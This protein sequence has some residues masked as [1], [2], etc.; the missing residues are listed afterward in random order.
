MRALTAS[1]LL[2][3]F[4]V[5]CPGPEE[6]PDAGSTDAGRVDAGAAD[7]GVA[8]AGSQ[9]D[10]GSDAG[11]PDAGAADAGARLEVTGLSVGI[12]TDRRQVVLAWTGNAARVRVLRTLNAAASGPFDAAAQVVFDGAASGASERVDALLP[13]VAGAPRRYT[14]SAFGCD[15]AN[16]G[17]AATADLT[18]S[19]TQAL[20][21]GGYTLFWRHASASTCGDALQLGT[22]ATTMS[23]GWWKS[24]DPV[25]ATAT[26]RQLTPPTSDAEIAAVRTYFMTRSIAVSRVLSSEYCRCVA[27]ATGFQLGPTVEQRPE[28]TYY[29][30]DEAN[31]CR[32]SRALINV[33]PTAGTNVAL[34]GHAGFPASCDP[35]DSLVWG[36]AAVFKPQPGGSPLLVTRVL[37]A[38]WA[39]LP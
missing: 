27:T 14:Y 33:A 8:D 11:A 35:L 16:C 18:L 12:S 34:V 3:V 36:E 1:C 5:A 13:E 31:R 4:L 30:Y 2:V 6:T 23:P 9:D 37:A 38:Q 21:G 15:G 17:A 22:A 10:G 32:D 7:A 29:V 24:C 19:L 26:A 20:Q 39:G 25:C 28:L